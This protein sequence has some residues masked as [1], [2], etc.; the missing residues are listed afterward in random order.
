M[1]GARGRA[2]GLEGI[3]PYAILNLDGRR[4]VALGIART[5]LRK[6]PL[7]VTRFLF[8]LFYL[9]EIRHRQLPSIAILHWLTRADAQR[10]PCE[11][12]NCMTLCGAAA[13]ESLAYDRGS[14]TVDRWRV[15]A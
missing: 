6:P 12:G 9:V 5:A 8:P 13:L 3:F 7:P 15:E 14:A 10:M 4:T 11:N 1:G 2:T